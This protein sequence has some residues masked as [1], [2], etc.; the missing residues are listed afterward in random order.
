MAISALIPSLHPP[1]LSESATT[2]DCRQRRYRR[3]SSATRPDVTTAAP[4]YGDDQSGL[5]DWE[6]V[7]FRMRKGARALSGYFSRLAYTD[8][9]NNRRSPRNPPVRCPQR[10]AGA[11]QTWPPKITLE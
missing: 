9:E 1:R 7:A 10:L 3:S 5:V 8:D 6:N 2:S 4:G 11:P